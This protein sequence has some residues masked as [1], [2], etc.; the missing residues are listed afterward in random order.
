MTPWNN[1]ELGRSVERAIPK[2]SKFSIYMILRL[3]PLSMGTLERRFK[4]IT[5]SIMRR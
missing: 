3:L 4:P 1:A 2:Q 5:R